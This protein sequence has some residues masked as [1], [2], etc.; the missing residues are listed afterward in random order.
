MNCNTPSMISDQ[1]GLPLSAAKRP[2]PPGITAMPGGRPVHVL[3]MDDDDAIRTLG[4]EALTMLGC[5]VTCADDGAQA[6]DA[7]RQAAA[8]GSR[9]DVVVLD[10]WV[11]DG[12]DGHMALQ[13]LLKTDPDLKAIAWTGR[14]GEPELSEYLKLGFRAA[15]AK[16][17]TMKELAEVITHVLNQ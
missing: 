13:R 9:F 16:P 12:M 6:V 10:L 17:C 8:A 14:P 15:I 1:Q 11:P 7:Y 3:L 2:H 5:R 4:K